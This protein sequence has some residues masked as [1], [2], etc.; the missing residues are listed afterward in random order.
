[1]DWLNLIKSNQHV[2]KPFRKRQHLC[3]MTSKG[4]SI[5]RTYLGMGRDAGDDVT[6]I[7]SLKA[8]EKTAIYLLFYGKLLKYSKEQNSQ[9]L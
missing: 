4:I 8:D 1:M 6:R 3:L 2:H 7:L 9:D 5:A